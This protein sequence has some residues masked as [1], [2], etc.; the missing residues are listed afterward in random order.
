M[1]C[2]PL[3]IVINIFFKCLFGCMNWGSKLPIWNLEARIPMFGWPWNSSLETG[4]NSKPNPQCVIPA[5]HLFEL[6]RSELDG[7]SPSVPLRRLI[8]R[9]ELD[10][11]ER[12]HDPEEAAVCLKI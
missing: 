10:M 5:S 11:A 6:P 1:N 12:P 7:I 3:R 8:D 2:G 4:Q 9:I